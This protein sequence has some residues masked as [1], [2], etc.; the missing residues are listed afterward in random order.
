MTADLVHNETLGRLIRKGGWAELAEGTPR[1]IR[2]ALAGGDDAGAAALSAF[3][4][5]EM[6]V[7][8]DIYTQWFH[9]TRR[10]LSDNGMDEDSLDRHH[11]EIRTK[12]APY[13]RSV[14]HDRAEVW[15]EI[16]A[17][18]AVFDEAGTPGAAK[19]A[20]LDKAM[21]LWRDLHDGEVDQLAGL[22]SLV[23]AE[24]GEE[25]LREM[26]EGWVIGDWF[27]KRYRRFDVSEMPWETA[28]WL[29]VYLGFEGHQGH[30]S[31]RDRDGTIDVFEDA[32][33]VTISFAP[34]G[35]GG[36]SMQGEARDGLPPLSAPPFNWPELKGAHDFT[37]N[38]TGICGYCAHCCILHETL[39]IAAFG[40]PVR[41]T[42]APKAP[43]TEESRCSWTVYRDL[44]AIPE[45][46]YARVGARKPAAHAPLGSSGRAAREALAKMG[47]ADG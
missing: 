18:L 1:L 32:E 10:Y 35:S 46:A 42:E 7:V 3:F 43:L 27:A 44:R 34:C 14:S 41:V 17:A 19:S 22:F 15:A 45:W 21:A 12:L 23:V 28:E 25:A 6:R 40:Y 24:H 16:A 8:H 36:R 30:L 29:L 2:R 39:P 38:E 37:W 9:D 33:K 13:H 11:G 47:R 20:A 4:L 31:G 5:S 26:Y